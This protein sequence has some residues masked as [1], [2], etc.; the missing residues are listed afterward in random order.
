MVCLR[1]IRRGA[2]ADLEADLSA[3]WTVGCWT[4]E[5]VRTCF[6]LHSVSFVAQLQL[7]CHQQGCNGCRLAPSVDIGDGDSEPDASDDEPPRKRVRGRPRK[8]DITGN[9]YNS[10]KI[11]FMCNK[12]YFLLLFL[13]Y[14][15]HKFRSCGCL[16]NSLSNNVSWLKMLC[17]CRLSRC[18]KLSPVTCSLHGH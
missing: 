3:V 5:N 12:V 9:A 1:S 17:C 10:A 4:S 14:R 7:T 6:A 15:S 11:V 18:Q 13:R 16:Q 8:G 2:Q